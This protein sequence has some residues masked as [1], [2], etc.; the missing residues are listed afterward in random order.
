[1]SDTITGILKRLGRQQF[2][3]RTPDRSYRKDQLEIMVSPEL[4][5]RYAF[6]VCPMCEYTNM[7]GSDICFGVEQSKV[8][9]RL[10]I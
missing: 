6:K 8:L 3:V 7:N 1:M 9:T 2:V 4:A 5:K 10:C